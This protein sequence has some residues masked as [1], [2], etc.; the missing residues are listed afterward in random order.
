MKSTLIPEIVSSN[1]KAAHA[2]YQQAFGAKD[3]SLHTTPDGAKVMHAALE[4]NGGVIFLVDDFP[5]HNGGRSR[6]PKA[7][8]GTTTTLHL[9]CADVQATWDRAIAAGVTVRLPLAK[10]FWGDTYGI[11]EDPFGQTWSF[12]AATESEK[13]DE[14]SEAYKEG[15]E[16]LFP[17]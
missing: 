2:F 16:K 15:A 1:A 4:I 6:N 5:E 12:S 9:N 13:P 8:G 10:Q 3:L 11:V 7:L 17:T 14:E